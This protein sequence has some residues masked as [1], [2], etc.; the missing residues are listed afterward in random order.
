M[1]LEDLRLYWVDVGKNVIQYYDFEHSEVQT[2][3]LKQPFQP[4]TVVVYRGSIFYA[5]QGD[6]AIH[7]AG[8]TKGENDRI[9]R[10]NTGAFFKQPFFALQTNH[11]VYREHSVVENL[12]SDHSDG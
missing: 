8:K 3:P 10:N 4:T 6:T 9:L 7:V 1:D 2:V 5:N 11:V 12:R